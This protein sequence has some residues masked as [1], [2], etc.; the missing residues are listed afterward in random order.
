MPTEHCRGRPHTLELS[1]PHPV[2]G[3]ELMG[4][5][6]M[7]DSVRVYHLFVAE[8]FQGQGIARGVRFKMSAEF[9]SYP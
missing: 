3:G 7:R 8:A 1:L 9:S 4:V 2:F 5:V 6:G